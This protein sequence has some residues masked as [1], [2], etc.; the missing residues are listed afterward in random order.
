MWK[1]RALNENNVNEKGRMYGSTG[2]KIAGRIENRR[3]LV[4][5]WAGSPQ[6]K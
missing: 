2:K 5:A 6:Y 3:Q 1:S 4:D